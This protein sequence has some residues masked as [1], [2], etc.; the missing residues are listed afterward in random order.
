MP[1]A[2]PPPK[3]APD[4]AP[5]PTERPNRIPWP[6]IIYLAA[7]GT[8]LALQWALPLP[9]LAEPASRLAHAAGLVLAVAA[10]ALDVS[11]MQAFRRQQTTIMPHR[12]ATSLITSGPFTFTRNPIYVANT[13]LLLGAS[14]A[15]GKLWMLLLVPV[16]AFLTQKL[17]IERE[18]RHLAARFGQ[19]WQDYAQRVRRW[20]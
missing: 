12:G 2:H 6:P 1:A 9:W 18:E 5:S 3:A 7:F 14:L 11:A 20:L 19:A 8:G 13:M 16:A 17:A 15:F 10:L 4:S